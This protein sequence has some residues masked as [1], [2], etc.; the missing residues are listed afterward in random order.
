MMAMSAQ[1]FSASTAYINAKIY[2][3]NDQQPWA[4]AMVIENGR[5]I[6]VGDESAVKPYMDH[7][8][9]VDLQGRL[10]LPGFIDEHVHPDMYAERLMNINLIPAEMTWE[11]QKEAIA[12]FATDNPGTGWLMGGTLNWL[13]DGGKDIQDTGVASHHST[14]DALVPDRPIMLLEQGGHS[15]LVNRAGLEALGITDKIHNPKGGVIV[16]DSQ[17]RPTGVLR[18]RAATMAYEAAMADQP[19]GRELIEQGI[20]PVFAKLNQFGITSI[21][22]SWARHYVI[23]AYK[24]MAENSELNVR[25]KAYV[26]NPGEWVS[27][28][29]KKAAANVIESHKDYKF[30]NW[31]STDGVKFVLDGSAGGQTIVMVDPYEGTDDVHGGPWRTD[32]SYFR[33]K[34]LEYDAMGLSIKMHAIGSQAIREALDVVAE[35]RQNGSKRNHTIAHT[36]FVHPDD[37]KRFKDLNVTAEFSPYF[38]HTGP[39]WKMLESE[40]GEHRIGWVFPFQTMV[41]LGINVAIGSDW[42]AVDSPNP[43]PAIE[44]MIT[45]QKPGSTD[46]P[47]HKERVSL[48]TAI[49]AMTLGGAYAQGREDLV[50]SIE[51]GKLADFIVL[52]RNLFEIDVNQIHQAEVVQTVVDGRI[53]F[54]QKTLM[55]IHP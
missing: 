35:A 16:Q 38:W 52:D 32:L 10:V 28:E 48:S 4:E 40:L 37:R 6:A 9:V 30:G 7:T 41:D 15:V 50:G 36:V 21:S 27:P 47:T 13:H 31:L 5:I 54:Q 49:K 51:V 33:E 19:R 20:K 39:V 3:V 23:D 18:E 44:S 1:A 17:G 25:V 2:T 46:T 12:T 26:A 8:P 34:F 29:S 45:R 24:Q 22:D 42:P 53:V 55:A 43:F 14:L 11:Q